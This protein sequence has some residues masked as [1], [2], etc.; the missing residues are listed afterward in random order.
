[1]SEPN[2]T[3]P[4]P[5]SKPT[6]PSKPYPEF[7]LTPHR[8][9]KQWCKKVRG[10]IHYF[11]PLDDPDAAL[12]KYLE[13]KDA[14]HAGRTP[15]PDPEALTV[16]DVANQ[17]L[18][19]KKDAVAA[20]ELSP[21]TWADY[22]SIMDAMVEG[23]GKSRAVADL[24]PQ[25]FAALKNKL[26]KKNGPTRMGVIVQVI[27][28]AFKYAYDVG[29]LDRPMRFGPSFKQP[30]M[31]TIRLHKAKQGLKLFSREEIHRML[32]AAGVHLKAMILLGVNAG[33]GNADVGRLPRS[34]LDLESGWVHFPR[35]KTGIDRRC[36]LWPETVHALRESLAVRPTPK[37][38]EH[39]G[40][41]FITKRGQP[42]AKDVVANPVSERTGKLLRR[43]GINGRTGLGFYTFRH[44]FRTV[45]DEARDQPAADHLMGHESSH[46]SSHYRERIS[47]ERLRAVTDHVRQW[48][49]PAQA[50]ATEFAE[51]ALPGE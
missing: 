3:S 34:A 29:T 17:F 50:A 49:F 39:N 44:V 2:S 31:K 21:R 35:P 19:A 25:D 24:G 43:L 48:L 33:F 15:R 32:D 27:R 47:D 42:W 30:S 10:K 16:K 20:G 6:K 51:P 18:N 38:A 37:K 26:A 40:L 22:R 4:A 9:A 7:P 41:T 36:P 45:A 46:M 11:G 28:C 5:S 23:F 13:Q 1:M 8:G 14:L 12:A